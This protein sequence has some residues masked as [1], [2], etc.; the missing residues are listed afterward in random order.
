[1]THVKT[2]KAFL[3]KS[4]C[5]EYLESL[6]KF[7]GFFLCEEE[8]SVVIIQ[9]VLFVF[10]DS[11]HCQI[12]YDVLNWE[13]YQG[14]SLPLAAYYTCLFYL[15]LLE[16]CSKATYPRPRLHLLGNLIFHQM[17]RNVISFLIHS[18]E[19]RRSKQHL[20]ALLVRNIHY[21]KK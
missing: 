10:N 20:Q 9:L 2:Q 6:F 16:K 13:G 5:I 21:L 19:E 14:N 4:W 18:A 8:V 17:L 1:M 3:P 15:N 11:E 7:C 12:T